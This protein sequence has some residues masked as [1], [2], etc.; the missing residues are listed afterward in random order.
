MPL[1]FEVREPG[2]EAEF[3]LYCE[4]RWRVLRQPLGRPRHSGIYEPGTLHLAAWRNGEVIGAGRMYLDSAQ[5]VHIRGM[6]VEPAYSHHGVGS[7]ILAEFE[8]LAKERGATRLVVE[9]RPASVGFYEKNGYRIVGEA[10]TGPH[11]SMKKDV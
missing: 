1:A 6:A 10:S 7:A 5:Q 4:L 3:N 9:S 2:N 11:V 8:R